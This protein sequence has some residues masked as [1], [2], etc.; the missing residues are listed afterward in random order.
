[1]PEGYR[2]SASGALFVAGLYSFP[3]SVASPDHS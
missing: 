3:T 1:V 2:A